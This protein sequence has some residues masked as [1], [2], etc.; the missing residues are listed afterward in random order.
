MGSRWAPFGRLGGLALGTALAVS[1]CGLAGVTPKTVYVTP[2]TS[3]G[4]DSAAVP[5][6]TFV[7]DETSLPTAEPTPTPTP[8]PTATLG[9]SASPTPVPSVA[10]V[11]TAVVSDS[12]TSP[13]C[14]AWHLSFKKPVVA[15][16]SG[17]VAMNGSIATKVDGYISA[18][19]SSLPQGGGAGPCTLDGAFSI[20]INS[21]TLLSLSFT[22]LEYLGGATNTT[23]A[24]SLDFGVAD[25]AAIA[26]KDLFTS[27]TAGAAAL[28]TQSR[29][30]LKSLLGSSADSSWIDAGTAPAMGNFEGAWVFRA[31]GLQITFKEL[32]VASVAEGTPTIVIPWASIKGV[33]R[34]DGPAGQFAA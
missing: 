33:L 22:V 21:K 28:S 8:T 24:G 11:T 29:P 18:F 32:Q 31:T 14:G 30:L 6:P 25:G 12:G 1:G 26:L 34:T 4:P 10:T 9:P 17:A 16:V 15:G 3:P 23:L 7:S 13:Q 19:M 20:G 2:G 5:T 27:A